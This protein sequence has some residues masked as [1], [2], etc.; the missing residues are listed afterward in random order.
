MRHCLNPDKP[1]PITQTKTCF[2]VVIGAVRIFDIDYGNDFFGSL[3]K[4]WV[5]SYQMSSWT[6]LGGGSRWSPARRGEAE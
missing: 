4:T 6:A 5:V 1:E 2:V 3:F